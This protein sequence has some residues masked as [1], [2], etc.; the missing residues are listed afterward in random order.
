MCKG[1]GHIKFN[2]GNNLV[3]NFQGECWTCGG[4]GHLADKCGNDAFMG[5]HEE[6]WYEE[7]EEYQEEYG[8]GEGEGEEDIEGLSLEFPDQTEDVACEPCLSEE[9]W[10][11]GAGWVSGPKYFGGP[12]C[13]DECCDD[14]QEDDNTA[15]GTRKAAG[16]D[17]KTWAEMTRKVARSQGIPI[18]QAEDELAEAI[19]MMGSKPEKTPARARSGPALVPSQAGARGTDLARPA[20]TKGSPGEPEAALRSR[21]AGG[22]PGQPQTGRATSGVRAEGETAEHQWQSQGKKRRGGWK[23]G[24]KVV[25]DEKRGVMVAKG[26]KSTTIIPQ[27]SRLDL[28][29]VDEE[30]PLDMILGEFA[31]SEKEKEGYVQVS[32][33]VDTGAEDHALPEDELEWLPI[34]ESAL[35]KAKKNFRGADGSRIPAKGRREFIGLTREGHKRKVSCEVCPVKRL[36]LSGTRIARQGNRVEIGD[37]DAYILN[38]KTRQKTYL[39]RERN[40]WMLDF[41]VKKPNKEGGFTRQGKP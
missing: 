10:G 6:E 17:Q 26:K 31:G 27:G 18:G 41:W 30:E 32:G 15:E 5:S 8:E 38:L 7:R 19:Q 23:E 20:I 13:R 28:F 2:C 25:W 22:A 40:V 9:S 35:S 39:R 36:L 24:K 1:V 4:Y 12:I 33:V 37:K 21:V 29:T 3:W 11:K 16:Y 34:Q 14:E